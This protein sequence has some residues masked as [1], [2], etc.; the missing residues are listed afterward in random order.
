M[1]KP[2]T[3][4][5]L[6]RATDLHLLKAY[7]RGLAWYEQ[8][9]ELQNKGCAVCGDGP[10]TRR[11][12]VDHDHSWTKVKITSKKCE[13]G[14][15]HSGAT[16]NGQEYWAIETTKSLA[17]KN[18][19]TQLLESSARGLL[20]HRCNRAMILFRDRTDLLN[21]AVHYLDKFQGREAV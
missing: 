5:Q 4:A 9:F 15:W 19:K 8:Q 2:K 20:C 7:G 6:D 13:C 21:K 14:E 1:S 16:Y 12:H 11:L 10:G 18:L 17:L 3:Q